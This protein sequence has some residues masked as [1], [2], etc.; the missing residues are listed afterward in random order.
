MT[1]L[2]ELIDF[3]LIWENLDFVLMGLSTTL[4]IALISFLNSLLIGTLIAI[5][6]ILQ[7]PILHW[8]ARFYVSF[9]RGV[10]ALVVLFFLYFGLPFAGVTL[11]AYTAAV[12][13]FTLT[14]SAYSSEVIRSSIIAI[15]RAQWEMAM[16]LGANLKQ[17]ITRVILP[18]ATRIAIPGLSNILLDLIKGTSLTAMITVRDIFQQA[19]IVAA[20]NNN[21]ITMYLLLAV[22][23]WSICFVFEQV[24]HYLERRYTVKE[25]PI[26][27]QSFS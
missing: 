6:R 23:Y 9:F 5:V 22:L 25:T 27:F 4:S 21:F 20:S 26:S 15:E 8:V 24:Q 19:K 7:V 1:P 13:G 3:Q 16:D 2:N 18:Q 11:E 17:V 12:I 10:P 14:A